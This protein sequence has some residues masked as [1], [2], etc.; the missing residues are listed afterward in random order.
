M[1]SAHSGPERL[2]LSGLKGRPAERWVGKYYIL[3]ELGRG[4]TATVYLAVARGPG[5]VR[6]LVVLKALLPEFAEESS[7]MSSFLDEA[8]LA[9]QLNHPNVVQTYEV[10]SE[11]GHHVIVMEYLEGQ[12]LS[13]ILRLCEATGVRLPDAMHFRILIEL[14]AG[15]HYVHEL[16]AYDGTP[17]NLVH[18]DVSPQNVFVTYDGQVKILD[19]GIAKAAT[20]ST[21]T[22]TGVLKGKISYMPS[23]QMSGG[24]VDRR[25][26][27]FAVGCLLWA[28]AAGRRLWKDYS[29]V[30]IV[31]LVLAGEI[32]SPRRV[33]P[34]CSP[35]LERIVMKALAFHPDDRYQTAFDMQMDLEAFAESQGFTVKQRDIGAFV[36][37]LFAQTRAELQATIERELAHG[38]A[39][40]TP[41]EAVP[42]PIEDVALG[43]SEAPPAPGE[44]TVPK[45][46][47]GRKAQILPWL[48]LAAG[49][50]LALLGGRLFSSTQDT[51]APSSTWS[52]AAS[53]A[54]AAQN[55]GT[56]TAAELKPVTPT[57]ERAKIQFDVEPAHAR[58]TLNG[59]PLPEGIAEQEL[60]LDARVHELSAHAEGYESTLLTFS[61][62]GPET[63]RVRL[64]PKPPAPAEPVSRPVLA[65]TTRATTRVE[66]TEGAPPESPD[67]A[68]QKLPIDSSKARATPQ[69]SAPEPAPESSALQSAADASA[70]PTAAPPPNTCQNPFFL[71]TEGI[72]RVRPECL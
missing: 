16:K 8:R 37:Q 41:D 10:G 18:R 7:A 62:K 72:K 2:S 1:L 42:G 17:L 29:Y 58:L 19:F 23:E 49:A 9:A 5:G 55:T 20:S 36:S 57:L 28:A 63:L 3:A 56:I 45:A 64:T 65:R 25:A 26:D 30:Q 54:H 11:G 39:N 60:P 22:A 44:P 50:A 67:T 51:A 34:Q 53:A 35:E 48:G 40:D 70:I 52:V 24:P 14:L 61:V 33:N 13:R 15:L 71:D 69:A 27:I 12:S 47:L 46:K 43:G 31:R 6:K 38:C 32:P 59:T 4:G 66:R 21:H 68:S